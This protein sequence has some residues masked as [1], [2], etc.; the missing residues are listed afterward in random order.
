MLVSKL[1]VVGQLVGLAVA[2]TSSKS[3]V[4]TKLPYAALTELSDYSPAQ[5]FCSSR[6]PLARCTTTATVTSSNL[7]PTI[8]A[9]VL[10]TT[11]ALHGSC[12]R[13]RGDTDVYIQVQQRM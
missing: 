7:T 5:S 6:Y 3:N 13:E 11:G 12:K 4:C 2:A 10:T 8:V 1:I 9:T